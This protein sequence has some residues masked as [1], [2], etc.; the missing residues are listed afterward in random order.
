MLDQQKR[1]LKTPI[2]LRKQCGFTL[3]EVMIA[4]FVLAVGMLGS[5]AMMMRGAGVSKE[6]KYDSIA[7]Q[8]ATNM[9]E[10]MR[11]NIEVVEL[12]GY[13]NLIADSMLSTNCSTLCTPADV[14]TYHALVWGQELTDL[15]PNRNATG[16]VTAVNPGVADS[17]FT[18]TVNWGALQRVAGDTDAVVTGTSSYTMI[19]QP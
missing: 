8:V 15:F 9:A 19:F 16:T 5:T 12:G 14:A 18:I 3:M 2:V 4:S 10:R 1:I 6:I 11:G 17:V 7:A 13:D